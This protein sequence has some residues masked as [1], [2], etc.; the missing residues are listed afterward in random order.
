[1][2]IGCDFAKCGDESS[3]ALIEVYRNGKHIGTT[4]ID[5]Y[6]DRVVY[7]ADVIKNLIE[8]YD[9]PPYYVFIK[10]CSRGE[11]LAKLIKGSKL[12]N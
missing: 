9:C 11:P 2:K 12:V 3:T 5:N 1:M 8:R 4:Y 10:N 6:E 7:T